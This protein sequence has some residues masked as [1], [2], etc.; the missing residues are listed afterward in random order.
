V[1]TVFLLLGSNQGDSKA[2]LAKAR[3]LLQERLGTITLSSGIYRTAAWGKTDQPDFLNQ[4]LQVLTHHIPIACLAIINQIEDE[5]G[6]QRTEHWGQRSIDIDILLFDQ[7]IIHSARL[8][9]PHPE[10]HKRNFALTPLCNIAPHWE[11]PVL[12][13]SIAELLAQ[14]TDQLSVF[15]TNED[16]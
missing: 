1:K 11:H 2:I 14:C 8:V 15:L 10:L 16:C 3:A 6:R 9:V 5:L 13:C 7:D 12:K 4:A